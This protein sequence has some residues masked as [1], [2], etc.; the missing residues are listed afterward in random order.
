VV[1]F[2][3]RRGG[4]TKIML[5]TYYSRIE[6]SDVVT[7]TVSDPFVDACVTIRGIAALFKFVQVG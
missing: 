3:L 6:P 7:T 2:Q 5:R 4:G 1:R